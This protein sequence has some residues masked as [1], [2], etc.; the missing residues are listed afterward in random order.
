MLL[1]GTKFFAYAHKHPSRMWSLTGSSIGSGSPSCAKLPQNSKAA[2]SAPTTSST[3]HCPSDRLRNRKRSI[4]ADH[5]E[6]NNYEGLGLESSD[7]DDTTL[8]KRRKKTIETPMTGIKPP[9]LAFPKSIYT[10]NVPPAPRS[11]EISI[12]QDV[13][14]GEDNSTL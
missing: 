12:L 6:F 13:H 2:T 9:P 7:Y 5:N 1:E 8:P 4:P 11:P 10:G 3:N 14:V